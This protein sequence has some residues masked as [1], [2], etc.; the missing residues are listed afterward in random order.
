MLGAGLA[1]K[2]SGRENLPESDFVEG[3][4][5]EKVMMLAF[6]DIGRER[7]VFKCRSSSEER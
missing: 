5:I 6:F 1:R 2:F 4:M 3:D 7:V